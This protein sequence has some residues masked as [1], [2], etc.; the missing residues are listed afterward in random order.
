M[1]NFFLLIAVTF[2]SIN[3]SVAQDPGK[4]FKSAEKTIKKY[5]SDSESVSAN[6]I[7]RLQDG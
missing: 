6:D 2:L 1:K 4:V 7:A 5:L 3:L